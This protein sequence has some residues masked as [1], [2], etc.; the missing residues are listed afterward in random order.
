MTTEV[1]MLPLSLQA[2]NRWAW[3][4]ASRGWKRGWEQILAQSRKKRTNG[5]HCDATL[6]EHCK[7]VAWAA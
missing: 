5:Y 2:K 6:P 7:W 3:P 4:A 1:A